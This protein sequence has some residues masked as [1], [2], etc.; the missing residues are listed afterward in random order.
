MRHLLAIIFT[1]CIY[2]GYTQVV[3]NEIQASNNST[4]TDNTGEYSDWLELYNPGS[5]EVNVAG[6]VLKDKIDTWRIPDGSDLTIIS[7]KGY[8]V[9][10]ADDEIVEGVL[11]TNFKLSNDG[12][13]LGIFESDSVTPIDTFSFSAMGDDFTFGRCTDSLNCWMIMRTPSPGAVNI[14]NGTVG[15][16][17]KKNLNTTPKIFPT[18]T[19]GI[20]NVELPNTWTGKTEIKIINLLGNVVCKKYNN[21]NNSNIDISH[22]KNGMY[23]L[24][25]TCG[26]YSRAE[27]IYKID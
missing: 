23:I 25:L 3:I 13:F 21:A 4:I 15:I 11:H 5:S 10:W 26:K 20:I 24:T 17:V 2:T 1:F 12:E 14:K 9:L 19:S 22:F 16:A 8:L 18:R 6:L 7:A 27:K